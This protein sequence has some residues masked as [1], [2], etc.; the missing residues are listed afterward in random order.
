MFWQ[1]ANTLNKTFSR[2]WMVGVGEGRDVL[3]SNIAQKPEVSQQVFSYHVVFCFFNKLYS[4]HWNLNYRQNLKLTHTCH[5][6]CL[7]IYIS[8]IKLRKDLHT[9]L[10]FVMYYYWSLHNIVLNKIEKLNS[11]V[12]SSKFCWK[13]SFAE[14]NNWPFRCF[15]ILIKLVIKKSATK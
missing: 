2:W 4:I 9:E 7:A 6:T 12:L 5:L 13:M 1:E 8:Y 15:Q 10:K 14:T 3:T 11:A